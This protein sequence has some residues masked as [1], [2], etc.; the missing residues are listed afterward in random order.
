MEEVAKMLEA[1]IIRPST[2]PWAAPVVLVGK[3]DGGTRV[4][5]RTLNSK[6]PLDGFPMPQKVHR[7]LEALYG[8]IVFSSLIPA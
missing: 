7:I 4:D 2:S 3:K 6:T 5:F 8:A 1:R